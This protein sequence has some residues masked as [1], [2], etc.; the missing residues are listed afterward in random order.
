MHIA[1]GTKVI[2][3]GNHSNAFLIP[4]LRLVIPWSP[5]EP[6]SEAF[7][8]GTQVLDVEL[9]ASHGCSC[10]L[11]A[12]AGFTASPTR[13]WLPG[14]LWFDSLS[15]GL[16]DLFRPFTTWTPCSSLGAGPWWKFT[17]VFWVTQLPKWNAVQK[18][19]K[20]P[21]ENRSERTP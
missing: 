4:I 5:H 6:D 18:G 7:L 20:F 1:L 3:S 21:K 8:L 19:E 13:K 15:L 12:S 9:D 11:Y 14:L 16:S 10:L 17:W 2:Q